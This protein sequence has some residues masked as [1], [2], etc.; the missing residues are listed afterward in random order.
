MAGNARE[1]TTTPLP[2]SGTFF[3]IKGGSASTPATF[4]PCCYASDTP[5]VPCDV[6]FRYIQEIP[7]Q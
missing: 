4:L 7:A 2:D 6:G 1:M 5:V 3:Q